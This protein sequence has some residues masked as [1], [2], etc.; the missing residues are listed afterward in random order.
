[1]SRIHLIIHGRVQGV[2][3]RASAQELAVSLGLTGWVRNRIDD[4]VELVA[5]GAPEHIMVIREWSR[6]GPAGAVV[7][8]VEE[9]AET[10]TGEFY[11]FY[12]RGSI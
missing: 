10:E 8:S 12:V 6:R 3:F 4:S 2:F 11:A 5:E 7:D 1:M 9:I